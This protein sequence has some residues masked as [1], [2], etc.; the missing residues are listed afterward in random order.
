MARPRTGDKPK[1]IRE[2]T[3]GEIAST[4]ST[5]VSVNKIAVRAG[6]SVGTLYRY[7]ETKDDLLFWVFLEVKR[8]IHR[9]MM[10]AAREC[11]GPAARLR[12]MWFALVA[13]GFKA[14]QEF[15]MAEMMSA[16]IREDIRQSGQLRDMQDAVLAEIQ[17]GI[18]QKVLVQTSV[19]TIETILASIAITLARRAS[20][21]GSPTGQEELDRIF[22]LI[23][24]GIA[25]ADGLSDK[26]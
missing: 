5:A 25:R 6:L 21:G 26:I 23:W 10:D 24:R 16:E 19:R 11:V 2:A 17:A 3:V 8:D 18:D 1:D 7:H 4:G 15:L 12:A 13:Y 20:L 22:T 14:P 9:S